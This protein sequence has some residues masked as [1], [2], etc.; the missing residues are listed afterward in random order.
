MY[1]IATPS[2]RTLGV[3]VIRVMTV[4]IT[5]AL[6]LAGSVVVLS[7]TSPQSLALAFHAELVDQGPSP[8]LA[9]GATATYTI[10]FRNIGIV[11]WQRGTVRQ[12]NLGVTG[13]SVEYAEAGIA[14][15]WLAP[16]RPAT[17]SEALVLP[18]MIGTFTFNV[19]APA[20]P[21]VYRVPLLPVADGVSWLEHDPV[22]LVLKSD[23]G[24]HSQ[25]LDQSAHPTLKPGEL[26]APITVRF[27]N[28]GAKTWTLGV[29][30]R[31]ANLG[32]A[33]DD[34]SMSALGFG[35]PSPDRVAIQ[36]EA[37]VRPGDVGTFTFR[38]RA[39]TA[40]GSYALPLRLV[41]DGITW[42]EDESAV[43]IITVAG[44]ASAI[45]AAPVG[46]TTLT[47][48]NIAKP[49]RTPTFA[50]GASVDVQNVAVGGTVGITATF[51]SD[52]AS[53]ATVGV[54][55]YAPGGATL[56]YQKWFRNET[57]TARH[58]RAYQIPWTAP[59]GTAIGTY[60]VTAAA[61][62]SGWKT[63]Y[64]LKSAAASFSVSAVTT[65][66]PVATASPLPTPVSTST[67]A[68]TLPAATPPG[69]TMT[70]APT[71]IPTATGLT[72]P[73][74]TPPQ[75]TTTPVP[76]PP[77]TA[78]ATPP[79]A[80]RFASTATVSATSVTSGGSM[81]LTVAVTS[82][83]AAA[84]LVDIEI[85]APG[86]TTAIYQVYFD[87]Q[88][89]A[90]GQQR[91]YP[92][93]WP[94]P[95]GALV[96]TY[97]VKLGV[98][99][100]S[101]ASL[102][103]WNDLAAIFSV[104][105]QAT[106]VPTAT[107]T[108]VATP[109]PSPALTATPTLTPTPTPVPTAAGGPA[110][111][112]PAR[113]TAWSPGMPGGV[114]A[115]TTVCANVSATTYGN[116]TQDATAGIQAALDA[117]PAGR[118]VQLSAGSFQVN[119]YLLIHSGITL[120]GAG[121]GVT[122]LTKTNGA[123]ARLSKTQPIDP[124][125]Y[126]YDTQPIIIV[127][128]NRWPKTDDTTSQALVLDGSQGATSVTVANA[129]G[130]AAGQIVLVDELSGASWQNTPNG[131]PGAA[132]VWAGDR[133]AWNMHWPLQQ[134]QDDN[135]FSDANGPYDLDGTTR[136]VPHAMSWFSRQDR[137]TNELKDIASVSGNTITFTT[138][139][140]ISY[141]TNHTAQVTRP[142]ADSVH[143]KN[144]GVE[145]LTTVG[146]ADGQVRFENAAYSWAKNIEVTQWIGEGVAINTSFRVELRDSYI[147]T[148]SWPTPG[149]AGYAVS[150]AGG[151]S[152]VLVE[153][154]IL[155]DTN[156]V[157]V[158]R[159]SG[160]GSVVGY[161][162]A[163]D[164]WISYDQGWQEVGINASH[165]SGPHHVLFEGN[166][167]QNADSDYT[168]GNAIYL[169]FFRNWLSGHRKSFADISNVRAVGLAY[170]SW[171]D[172][173]VGNVLGLPGQ[174][175][176]WTYEDPAMTSIGAQWGNDSI[177][178]LGYDPERWTMVPDP[179]VLSTVIREGNF[180]YV[181]NQVHWTS[182]A[183]QLPPSLYL[184]S[185][186]TFFGTNPWPWVDPTGATKVFTLPARAR[187]DAM[188]VH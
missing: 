85:W 60:T 113:L 3:A 55:I 97:T 134:Y 180:D 45:A 95:A 70:S 165:M 108:L 6:L 20:T 120:R 101:W 69:P 107:P 138:P 24:F 169:T 82:A 1:A 87:N 188:P 89:F 41:V 57:F 155:S 13:N 171:W 145:D 142:M 2:P 5:L 148:G 48:N 185:K 36:T 126:Q 17:T 10:R 175:A 161:N 40:P 122:T 79:P 76:P 33:D 39:P 140:T 98:F 8:T 62:S 100:P 173:F 84:A 83:T 106:P 96:G 133:V 4:A 29:A 131:F 22:V 25:R 124:S 7:E 121:P 162:Y 167:S 182:A 181:T 158:M 92:A 21:G 159:S 66:A 58:Q 52:I 72:S 152:Q 73:T 93:A 23:L 125:T 43:T 119:N 78:T 168:H 160:A 86:A 47:Q 32:I 14:V 132:K 28:T 177:W 118:V 112:P 19:R 115:R 71:P 49:A 18:G 151:S 116:G 94:V 187:F 135:S 53:S 91:S 59:A 35:W 163:D 139:L 15:G 141:R 26:S 104:V 186:P 46:A 130:F 88:T 164:G 80:P 174:M 37:A 154:N 136:V 176:G 51:M 183:Q 123:H 103:S 114:P 179:Q 128:P 30:G 127:G 27:R 156:K 129:A 77:P 150:F 16:S 105:P 74:P 34:R 81:G 68:P 137:P 56:V 153:N 65:P 149:G 111:I 9:P 178:K 144:A 64:G 110:L 143:V 44:T 157:M 99:A 90:A 63:Q 166:Y 170:G 147:H 11:P 117:C 172:S 31:Q 184:T 38:V 54:E 75:P 67:A 102:Y 12:V 50:I 42:M 146:G 109:T 61:Y